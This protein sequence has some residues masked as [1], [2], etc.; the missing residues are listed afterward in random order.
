MATEIEQDALRV[1]GSLVEA[2]NQAE[3]LKVDQFSEWV[4]G[5][6]LEETL[7]LPPL[8]IND[9]VSLLEA[10]GYAET[11][12]TMGTSPFTFREVAATPLGSLEYQRSTLPGEVV[13]V[14]RVAPAIAP[15]PRSPIPV[16]SPYGFVEED[17]EYVER[18]RSQR[19]VLKVVVGYQFKSNHYD[20]RKLLTMLR[21]DFRVALKAYNIEP[22]HESAT[23]DFRRLRA[24]YGG[25]LFNEIARDLISA[26][27]AVFETSDHNP[28]VMIEMGV[29]LTW[30]TRVL[31]IKKRGRPRPPSDI[32]GHTWADYDASSHR[33]VDDQHDEN[34][35]G[36]IRRALTRKSGT[37]SS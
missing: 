1:L 12:R 25:H 36:M 11:V 32:S 10:N 17:W 6:Q 19:N 8:R 5:P 2:R 28:N 18:E 26:D 21:R 22:G 7:D 30:G 16:G 37:P 3:A 27:I 20:T 4:T 23:L 15:L 31:P 24:G 33:F 13:Q 14:E 9:A 35:L 34:L 29:A